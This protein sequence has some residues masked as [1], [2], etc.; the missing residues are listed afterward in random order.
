MMKTTLL[1]LAFLFLTG[2]GVNRSEARPNPVV[3]G[4][5]QF[6][7]DLYKQLGEKED[8]N[9][10]FSPYSIS[11][12]LAMTYAGARGETQDEMA[13][14]LHFALPQRLLHP[15]FAAIIE[16]L[17]DEKRKGYKLAVANRLWGQ[18]GYSFRPNFLNTTRKYYGAELA[19]V[20]F[21]KAAE[22]ARQTINKWVEEQTQDKIKDLIP[23]GVLDSLTRLVLT[24]AIYFKGD[25]ETQFDKKA[26][27]EADFTATPDKKVKV[28]MMHQV[29][30]F[31]YAD[32]P[33]L[34]VLE[35]PY[36]GDDLS[37]VVLLPKKTDGLGDLEKS[38]D[39]KSLQE[40]TGGVRKRKVSVFLPKFKMTCK[41][42]LK[43]VLASMGMP[44]AFDAGRADF[45]GMTG[46]KDLYIS[47]VIHKAFVDV[48]EEGTE[49][50]AATAVVMTLR[51]APRP[52]PVFRADH[53]FLFLIR[54]N[55]TGSILFLGRVA[56]PEG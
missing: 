14:V 47:A 4:N 13:K 23:E 31:K 22:K 19:Q 41:F 7:L 3:K 25:W 17:N 37:M 49:A 54:D 44:L 27:R 1:T 48:N 24:N 32:L 2:T 20:D 18:K 28:P 12:A 5:N 8:G 43:P 15:A 50:A 11:T 39:A 34:Q 30:P 52:S 51:S 16:D 40:W 56:E 6:A 35:M 36:A 45:S 33:S 9:L 10:L 21:A 53:P 46:S 42:R 26:T 55:R 29:A 38:L